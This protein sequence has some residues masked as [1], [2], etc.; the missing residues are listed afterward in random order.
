VKPFLLILGFLSACGGN[1][2]PDPIDFN[3][4]STETIAMDL[5]LQYEVSSNKLVFKGIPQS[6]VSLFYNPNQSVWQIQAETQKWD[7]LKSDLSKPLFLHIF[8]NISFLDRSS[9]FFV[10]LMDSNP[11]GLVI[12]K[13][14]GLTPDPSGW[15]PNQG[16]EFAWSTPQ[17]VQNEFAI[18]ESLSIQIYQSLP[19]QLIEKLLTYNLNALEK[20]GKWLVAKENLGDFDSLKNIQI[21][22]CHQIRWSSLS[23]ISS[24][25]SA[26]VNPTTS[27]C[28]SVFNVAPRTLT[29]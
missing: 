14:P 26:N 24:Q 4:V 5:S 11:I 13:V 6:K 27:S 2:E 12:P 9:Q 28:S 21:R 8:E 3:P 1:K 19:E 10:S 22:L 7:N 17:R 18:N 23:L 20:S 16:L 29:F 15:D 25:I